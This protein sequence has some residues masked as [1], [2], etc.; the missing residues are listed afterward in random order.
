[1]VSGQDLKWMAWEITRRCNLDFVHCRS[2]SDDTWPL[3]PFSIERAKA[4]LD[5]IADYA[6]PVVVLTGG[7][8]LLRPDV[9]DIAT[10][11]S[12]RGLRMCV[13]TNGLLVDDEVEFVEVL[14]DRLEA[15]DL[16]VET[17]NNEELA[18]AKAEQ[19]VFD[20]ILLDLA[21]PGMDG[22]Q[23]LKALLGQNPDLQVIL[24]TGQATLGQAVDA[25]KLG[26]LDFLEKP[27]EIQK[28]LKKIQEAKA[29]KMLL[30]EQRTEE[31]GTLLS[32]GWRPGRP[33]RSSIWYTV[34]RS[35]PLPRCRPC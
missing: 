33:R 32:L 31:V 29:N 26:A 11:G 10:H 8:P 19:K 14:A 27:A 5:E 9:F 15:R 20:A 13:A 22:I 24:L 28:L 1:M 17:A 6:S 18:L 34:A 23:T 16:V 25:M 35:L 21:M 3:M 12:A 7:E 30:V 2:S 4:I